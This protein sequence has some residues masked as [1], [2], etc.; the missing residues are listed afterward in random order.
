MNNHHVSGRLLT[1]HFTFNCGKPYKLVVDVDSMPFDKSPEVV[2]KGLELIHKRVGLIYPDA[3]FNEIL[4]VGY[5][6]HDDGEAALG[7]TV[8]SIYLGPP[9][10]FLF[11]LKPKYVN[12]TQRSKSQDVNG[13]M[14]EM[15][16]SAI[17]EGNRYHD[18]A[19][20]G[21][22]KILVALGGTVRTFQIAVTAR[23]N[24]PEHASTYARKE[25]RGPTIIQP[26]KT[27][28]NNTHPTPPAPPAPLAAPLL[29]AASVTAAPRPSP[30]AP[31]AHLKAPLF[32]SVPSISA[33][34]AIRTT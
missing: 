16:G 21:Y 3:E 19:G 17:E 10:R 5:F 8:A 31:P 30:P 13:D 14:L 2:N 27:P 7:D 20:K 6:Y 28:N 11:H 22:S 32:S 26:R 9:R 24:T 4:S 25:A 34:P 15:F 29:P 23:R 33:V 12:E 18:Y 1:Q